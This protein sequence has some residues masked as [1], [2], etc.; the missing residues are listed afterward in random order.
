M[1]NFFKFLVFVAILGIFAIM[2]IPNIGNLI[3]T[4]K[5]KVKST[6]LNNVETA[7]TTCVHKTI[8]ACGQLLASR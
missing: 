4:S 6:I 3:D 7:A 1:I 5:S 8:E 2:L